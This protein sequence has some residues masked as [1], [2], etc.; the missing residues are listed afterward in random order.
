MQLLYGTTNKSKIAFMQKRVLSL[1]IDLISLSDVSAPKLNIEENGNSPLDNA[2]IKALAYYNALKVPLFSCD[3][4]LYI[5][6]LDDARQPGINVRGIG[7]Y[8]SDEKAISHYSAL[9]EEMGGR[10]V[11]RYKNAICMILNENQIFEH[12]GD[13]IATDPFY[14]VSTPHIKRNEGFPLDS[15]SVHME[16]GKYYSDCEYAEIY[17]E[18]DDGFTAF[19]R[20]VLNL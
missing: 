14:L 17:T 16:N 6:G 18:T 8:M 15:L 2:K 9:A 3:S 10:M 19:F 4:G 7:D 13:D 12:M 1:G 20:K 11:A 5:E